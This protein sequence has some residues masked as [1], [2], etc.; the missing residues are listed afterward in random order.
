MMHEKIIPPAAWTA[1][2]DDW[3]QTVAIGDLIT[4]PQAPA[5]LAL[6]VEVEAV[7]GWGVLTLAPGQADR[8]QPVRGAVLRVRH[9]EEMRDSGLL[10]AMRFDLDRRISVSPTHPLLGQSVSPVA[11]HLCETAL[12][13]LHARRARIHA[14]RD[15]AAHFRAAGRAGDRRTG[16][17]ALPRP[18]AA[19]QEG[20][21]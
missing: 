15:I 18:H 20:R 21:A 11:G 19:A 7:R 13:R 5:G 17:R 9:I 10:S 8:G 14:L 1:G 6:V 16:W 3:R 12:A 2:G 4:W